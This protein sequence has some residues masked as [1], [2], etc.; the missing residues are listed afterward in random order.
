MV[1]HSG[2]P[3]LPGIIEQSEEGGLIK[4]NLELIRRS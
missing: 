4:D 1:D 2:I 3:V